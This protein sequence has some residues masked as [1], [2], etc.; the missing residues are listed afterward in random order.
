MYSYCPSRSDGFFLNSL[1]FVIASLVIDLLVGVLAIFD[2]RHLIF[3]LLVKINAL[4][5]IITAVEM[6]TVV[7][8]LIMAFTNDSSGFSIIFSSKSNDLGSSNYLSE[9]CRCM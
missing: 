6:K 5:R 2:I 8:R 7:N 3:V 9:R 1:L 4:A